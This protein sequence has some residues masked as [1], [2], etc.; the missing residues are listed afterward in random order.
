VPCDK[1]LEI[2]NAHY[3]ETFRSLE[4][5]W[6]QRNRVALLLY[7]TAIV[8]FVPGLRGAA[9]TKYLAGSE[10]STEVFYL[11]L[12]LI[13]LGL[14]TLLVQRMLFLTKQYVYLS[15]IEERMELLAGHAIITREGQFYRS[16]EEDF[17]AV[18]EHGRPVLSSPPSHL[19]LRHSQW[20]I[21][22]NLMYNALVITL[23]G[24]VLVVQWARIYRTT[25]ALHYFGTGPVYNEPYTVALV[26]FTVA[27]IYVIA[28]YYVASKD[29]LRNARLMNTYWKRRLETLV[30]LELAA[31]R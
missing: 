31:Y 27:F 7:L 14:C 22:F 10:L 19:Q 3:N 30:E 9:I 18:D 21:P 17:P 11:L 12:L 15:G 1:Q 26:L 2:L 6:S 20:T 24:A 4:N 16:H 5:V 25:P 8:I 28:S 29:H 13:L 23:V